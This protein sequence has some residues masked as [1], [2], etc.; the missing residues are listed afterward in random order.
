[1]PIFQATT[2][3]ARCG[4]LMSS[5]QRPLRIWNE[6]C[7][8]ILKEFQP[9]QTCPGAF[10][11]AG[12]MGKASPGKGKYGK[13]KSVGP[14]SLASFG[15]SRVPVASMKSGDCHVFSTGFELGRGKGKPSFRRE[16]WRWSCQGLKDHLEEL[17]D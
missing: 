5:S 15:I 8:Q 12:A 3:K 16:D 7:T 13:N 4:M 11:T 14:S 9:Q 1:M 10:R 2:D 17:E 6:I